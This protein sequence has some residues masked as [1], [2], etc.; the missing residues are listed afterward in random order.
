M[1]I[2]LNY[3]FEKG[4]SMCVTRKA[5]LLFSMIIASSCFIL[6]NNALADVISANVSPDI[7]EPA[8]TYTQ[9]GQIVLNMRI[10]TVI[11]TGSCVTGDYSG[12]TLNDV[13]ND[14][15]ANDDFKP[16]VKVH[17]VADDFPDDGLVSNATLRQRG[18]TSRNGPQKSF[19]VKLKSKK[20]LWRGERR[21]Q[22]I[23]SVFDATRI[24][25]KLSY[26][27]FSEIPHIP[28]M[29][30]Q[31]VRFTVND[32]G[33][34]EDYGLYTHV[35]HFGKEYLVR[36]GWDKD[37]RVYKAENMNFY[38]N[39]AFALNAAGKPVNLNAFERRLEIKRGKTHTALAH[40]IR[41]LNN[42]ALDFNT[43]IMGKYFN[44]DNYL[45]WFAVNILVG[46]VDTNFHNF[47]LY[48]PKGTEHFYLVPWDY[49]LSFGQNADDP[50]EPISQ[51]PRWWF[52]QGNWWEILLHKRFLSQPGNLNL[53]KQA[54]AE[55]KNKYLTSA[56]IQ[57]KANSYYNAVFPILKNGADWDH[58]YIASP[59]QVAGYNAIFNDLSNVVEQNY[60][61]FLLR[62]NDPM[63]FYMDPPVF[64]ANHDIFFEWSESVSLNNQ[65]ITYDLEVASDKTFKAGSIIERV[66]GLT[67]TIHKLH[68]RH[69]KGTYYYRIIARDAANPQAH[70]QS[71]FNES[72]NYDNNVPIY[73]IEKMYVAVDGDTTPPPATIIS[74]PVSSIT[75]DG[76]NSEW[77]SLGLFADDPDDIAAGE[78]NVIDW[79]NAGIAHNN[80]NVYFMYNNRG[81][82]DPVHVNGR[83]VAWG[84]Q[85]MIDTDK[86]P[87]TGFKYTDVVGVDYL[88]TGNVIYR[89]TG[90]GSDW[91]WT[92]VAETNSKFNS[93]I[94]ELGFTRGL[95]G[96]PSEIRVVFDGR[97]AAFGGSTTDIYPDGAF[98]TL[99]ANRYFDYSFG[100]V[101][102]PTNHAPVTNNQSFSVVEN[103]KIN[104]S[105]SA[106]DVDNDALTLSIVTQPTHGSLVFS[107]TSL[108]VE[109][110]PVQNYVG[111]DSFLYS[112][113]DGKA[114]SNISKVSITVN[115]TPNPSV[116]S[117][118]VVIGA[119][120]VNG[121]ATDWNGLKLFSQD[122]DD[123]TSGTNN[124]IDWDQI[125]LAHS[126]DT[127]YLLYKNR[128]S[129]NP[130]SATGSSLSWGYQTFIDTDSNAATGFK[131]TSQFAPDYL[132]E[133]RHL[134]QYVGSGDDWNWIEIGTATVRYKNNI[135]ELS[136]PRSLLGTH[137]SIKISFYGNNV[138]FGGST[139]DAYP[140]TGSFQ[141]NFGSGVSGK[142]V[143]VSNQ[144]KGVVK[145][146]AGHKVKTANTAKPRVGSG[147]ESGGSFSWMILFASL[148]LMRRRLPSM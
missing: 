37:S 23:K 145:S 5:S 22:L 15:V 118:H 100:T 111:A 18:A 36:R 65:T 3:I 26:D 82:I 110:T 99:S 70:W 109:Y 98:D 69:L 78:K 106:T 56:K 88:L 42:P 89:Y 91:N 83:Y 38:Q 61:R 35:E 86:N 135:A 52:S 92:S 147:K 144:Q 9:A 93:N 134:Y 114:D 7:Q 95:I 126:S 13:L 71:A 143:A 125:G 73:G 124:V 97:N 67:G 101:T 10:N 28:S 113:N 107:P 64:Q 87:T 27:L 49:D 60:Q 115:S 51:L 46:N 131:F 119:I 47:Y 121:T 84:Y 12:C 33:L 79:K 55:V 90:T 54:V 58:I 17:M 74:N 146:P 123:V 31:F 48:N 63:P 139:K 104:M 138:A 141:Y 57:S 132:L 50:S 16:E 128:G 34:D 130:N 14:V 24:R 116:I 127:V 133:G 77:T 76:N 105:L 32:T 137:S 4:L 72:V 112:V 11:A 94:F 120:T 43:Q 129:V 39:S 142:P 41:D 25:N 44:R 29:R 53:L 59:D 40:M 122:P 1:R 62:A 103:T 8:N 45:T 96:N 85:V 68:W 148:L 20:N 6:L 21:I 81:P 66:T 136:F 140:D 117:N 75:V 30:T 19:R 102:P 108:T 2:I 80:Q